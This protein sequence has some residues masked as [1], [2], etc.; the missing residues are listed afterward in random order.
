VSIRYVSSAEMVFPIDA[1]GFR[2]PFPRSPSLSS[3]SDSHQPNL[4]VIEEATSFHRMYRDQDLGIENNESRIPSE[5][6]A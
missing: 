5:R 4:S 3:L 6:T 1:P 2:F